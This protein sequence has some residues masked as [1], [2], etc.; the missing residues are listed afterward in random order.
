M[1]LIN[2]RFNFPLYLLPLCLLC[3][4]GVSDPFLAVPLRAP[5]S[6]ES[7]HVSA[8]MLPC[9]RQILISKWSD[10]GKP[11][12]QALRGPSLRDFGVAEALVDIMMVG[13]LPV[14]ALTPPNESVGLLEPVRDLGLSIFGSVGG[15]KQ[16][17][18]W[19][20]V[21]HSVEAAY[22]V[23]SSPLKHRKKYSSEMTSTL[24]NEVKVLAV[25]AVK[26]SLFSW[27]TGLDHGL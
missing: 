5:E 15:L 20:W 26:T 1:L 22:A 24:L 7:C 10:V 23:R 4:D 2:A 25:H 18:L 6:G 8:M 17:L 9:C 16:V 21:A 11:C 19:A 12:S 13:V 3:W 14:I 27:E